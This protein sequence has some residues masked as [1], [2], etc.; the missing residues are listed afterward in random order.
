M[1]RAEIRRQQPAGRRSDNWAPLNLAASPLAACLHGLRLAITDRERA[2]Q[3]RG[4]ENGPS[5]ARRRS[6]DQDAFGGL[7]PVPHSDEDAD[8]CGV[9]E[10]HV[11]EVDDQAAPG[12]IGD[13]QQE[14]IAQQPAGQHINFADH[15][16]HGNTAD[17]TVPKLQL[18][19]DPRSAHEFAHVTGR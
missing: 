12:V 7:Y 18:F 11:G 17:Q 5:L 14:A 19:R 2:G 13:G 6:Q 4:V 8:A 3:A 10:A 1:S 15:V 16:N 9:N